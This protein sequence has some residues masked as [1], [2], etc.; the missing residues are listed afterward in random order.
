MDTSACAPAQGELGWLEA[1]HQQWVATLDALRDAIVVVDAGGEVL[2]ANV[3]FAELVGVEVNRVRGQRVEALAPWLVDANG[4]IAEEPRQSPGGKVVYPRACPADSRLEG[5]VYILDDVTAENALADTERQLVEGEARSYGNVVKS[6]V[7]AQSQRDPYTAQHGR[8][9]ATLSRG[10]A[11]ALGYDDVAAHGIYYG[12]LIHDLGKLSVPS[13]IL[14]KPGTL[15][16]AELNLIQMHPQTGYTIVK[17]LDF[18]W[19]VKD[20]ILQ[21]HERLD[22]SGYPDGLSGAQIADEARIVG[23]AD[24]VEAMSSH[25]PYRPSRGL[26]AALDEIRGGRGSRYDK[27]AVDACLEVLKDGVEFGGGRWQIRSEP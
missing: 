12:A 1:I 7:E 17:N 14:N 6:L 19:P 13:S 26:Q 25:R 4:W 27:G 11:R 5:R 8:N 2:R 24:V 22:G 3:S 16:Q 9:V 21:H 20:I 15:A 23:V 18:P 10:I